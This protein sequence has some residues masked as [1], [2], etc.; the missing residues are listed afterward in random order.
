MRQA[1]KSDSMTSTVMTPIGTTARRGPPRIRSAGATLL[2][3][4]I[5]V[6]LVW[7]NL[8]SLDYDGLWSW[9]LTVQLGPWA[10]HLDLRTWV[11]SGLMTLFFL[12][13]GLEARQEFDLGDLR[14]RRR[15]ALPVLAG[16]AGM[17]IPVSIY[18]IVNHGGAGAVGWGIA[19]STDTALALG[20]FSLIAAHAPERIRTFVLTVF[21]VDDL[22]ALIVIALAYSEHIAV[23][24]MA[25]A[26]VAYAGL[27]AG[28]RLPHRLRGWSF[29]LGTVLTWAGLLSAG[30]D[31]VVAGLAAGLATTAYTPSRTELQEATRLV[32]LF[33]EQPSA[34]LAAVATRGLA[35][36]LSA[37]SRMRHTLHAATS[38]GIVPLFALANAGIVIDGDSLRQALR[39]PITIGVVLAYVVGKP[40]AVVLTSWLAERLSGGSLRP[41]VGWGAVL[42]SGTIAGIGFTVS[43]L[44][45]NLA[46][47]GDALDQAKIGI[48]AAAA[49]AALLSFAVY[50][51]IETL[52]EGV[53]ARALLG[54]A[55]RLVDLAE[56]VD[57]NRDHIQGPPTA[58]VTVVE[59]GDFECP[60]TAMVGP[61]AQELLIANTDVRYV[62]RHLPL[63]DVH[64]YAQTAA[65]AAEAAGD[66]GAFWP[67]HTLLLDR[68]DRLTPDDLTGYAEQLGLDLDQ[69][70]DDLARHRHEARVQ[71]DI[72]SADRSGVAGTPT[73]FVNGRR[74]DG[75]QDLTTLNR[76]IDEARAQATVVNR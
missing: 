49:G 65:E 9:V 18:L 34:K 23:P 2:V 67:M 29:A 51:V 71:R 68:Q 69:F 17:V 20:A 42:E 63:P 61:T 27:L 56:P 70:R 3:A 43:L 37:N 58:A 48:L 12:V 72:D 19:M 50:R 44:I 8:P 41:P 38:Y 4:A 32:R 55:G 30:V 64:P 35:G 31:P 24:G 11:N 25:V 52:P 45:A 47:T 66:Q 53:R 59:Y 74:H 21:V 57:D 5:A 22:V 28:R 73:F 1:I 60:W 39:S 10:A 7:A 76:V 26:V 13:V 75:P 40:A 46:F 54:T 16:A 15:L 62:W 36:A 14:E 33:R 6:A